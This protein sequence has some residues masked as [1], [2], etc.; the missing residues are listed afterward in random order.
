MKVHDTALKHG[1]HT[2][3]ARSN[4]I[5]L[6]RGCDDRGNASVGLSSLGSSVWSAAQEMP[7]HNNGES[8]LTSAILTQHA[9]WISGAVANEP[10]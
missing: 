8:Y 7:S 5:E 10:L 3:K 4:V 6:P 1:I 9:K 2:M